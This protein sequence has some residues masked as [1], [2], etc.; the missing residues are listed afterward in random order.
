MAD[1]GYLF[2]NKSTSGHEGANANPSANDIAAEIEAC[3]TMFFRKGFKHATV[4]RPH[5]FLRHSEMVDNDQYPKTLVGVYELLLQYRNGSYSSHKV[6]RNGNTN[7]NP[8]VSFLKNRNMPEPDR[9]NPVA[10]RD[11]NVVDRL[12]FFTTESLFL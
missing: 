10:G 5:D 7:A 11:G 12:T 4:S 3:K 6:N 8:R 1:L 2:Y 9:D